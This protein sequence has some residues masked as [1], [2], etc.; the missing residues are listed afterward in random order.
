MLSAQDKYILINMTILCCIC[1]WHALIGSIIYVNTI[2]SGTTTSQLS[3]TSSPFSTTTT[4]NNNNNSTASAFY[5][6][7]RASATTVG[8]CAAYSTPAS[9]PPTGS[10][11]YKIDKVAVGTFGFVYILFHLVFLFRITCLVSETALLG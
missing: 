6:T 4:I 7:T 8:A 3:N 5:S 10:L 11:P 9:G 2:N 1:I